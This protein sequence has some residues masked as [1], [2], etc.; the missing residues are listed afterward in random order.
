MSFQCYQNNPTVMANSGTLPIGDSTLSNNVEQIIFDRIRS[1]FVGEVQKY[2]QEVTQLRDELK[3]SQN[4][5]KQLRDEIKALTIQVEKLIPAYALN[6]IRAWFERGRVFIIRS[7]IIKNKWSC[8]TPY[9]TW[10]NIINFSGICVHNKEI[11]D[12]IEIAAVEK[13]KIDKHTWRVLN[14]AFS[15]ANI[16]Y[17]P[18]STAQEATE[19]IDKIKF[20]QN[21]FAPQIIS[22]MK[23]GLNQ[24]LAVVSQNSTC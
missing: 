16:M 1:A 12:D 21:Y 9:F 5:V 2:I 4:E 17:E 10:E 14:S 13:F 3:T 15:N 20:N 11:I 7:D 8:V 23:W 22:T 18:S 19:L 24:I 6:E